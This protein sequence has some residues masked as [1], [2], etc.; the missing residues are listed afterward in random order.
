M[1][2]Q[3]TG[4]ENAGLENSRPRDGGGKCGTGKCRTKITGV[5]NAGPENEG[6]RRIWKMEPYALVKTSMALVPCGHSHVQT[7]VP[8][9]EMLSYCIVL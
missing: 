9:Q 3:E 2:D 7:P 6:P 1:R 5:E 4:A 8:P